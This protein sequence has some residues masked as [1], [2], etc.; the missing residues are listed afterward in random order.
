[1]ASLSTEESVRFLHV[2]YRLSMPSCNEASLNQIEWQYRALGDLLHKSTLFSR[3]A[4]E[5]CPLSPWYTAAPGTPA[6]GRKVALRTI[7][8]DSGTG[9][10]RVLRRVKRSIC[11]TYRKA[12]KV[13]IS[14]QC[15]GYISYAQ[16]PRRTDHLV[17]KPS[18]HSPPS[19]ILIGFRGG[20]QW[21]SPPS[22]FGDSSTCEFRTVFHCGSMHGKRWRQGR[23]RK[24]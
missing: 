10:N 6:G 16:T 24:S 1:L 5:I 15:F 22:S 3:E 14:V 4:P 7:T 12:A 9:F 19:T 23:N 2:V 11:S 8:V 17:K 20:G 18:S 13:G 21:C